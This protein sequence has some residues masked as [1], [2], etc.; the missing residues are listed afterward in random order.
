MKNMIP[1]IP[2]SKK[3][4]SDETEWLMQPYEVANDFDDDINLLDAVA[5]AVASLDD[6]DKEM[7]YL[8][9]YERKTFQQAA[10]AVGISA[11]SHAWRKTK[12]A[13]GKLEV[14]LKENPKIMELLHN[15]YG[16]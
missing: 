6:A 8:I 2:N 11:K 16:E 10:R 13:L 5:D 4:R 9:Y 15:K 12:I 3:Y 14:I 7:L 1:D